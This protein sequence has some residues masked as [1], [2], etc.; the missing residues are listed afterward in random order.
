M[1]YISCCSVLICARSRSRDVNGSIPEHMPQIA[2]DKE[3]KSTLVSA[4][5]LDQCAFFVVVVVIVVKKK[6]S[7]FKLS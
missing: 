2:R 3:V 1:E 7:F 5:E 4:V 6:R